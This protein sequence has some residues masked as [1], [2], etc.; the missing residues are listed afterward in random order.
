MMVWWY[1]VYTRYYR[2]FWLL[3]TLVF[4]SQSLNVYNLFKS[5]VIHGTA[6]H[7]AGYIAHPSEYLGNGD[8][9]SL[10]IGYYAG[11]S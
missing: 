8:A 10:K 6:Q 1:D 5:G 3:S 4:I 7:C 11:Q 2:I 9:M